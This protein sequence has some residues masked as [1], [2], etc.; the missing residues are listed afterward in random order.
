MPPDEKPISP[1]RKQTD[2]SLHAERVKAD[3]ALGEKL[4]AIDESADAVITLARARAD[5]V[6]AAARAKTDRQAIVARS[7]PRA[8]EIMVDARLA[9]DRALERERADADAALQGE[10]DQHV[11]LLSSERKDTDEHLQDE[12][13]QSDGALA[14]RDEFMGIVSHDLR[15]MLSTVVGFAA[16][17]EKG[18]GQPERADDMA[19][20]ARRIQRAAGRMNRLIGDLVDIASIEAGMLTVARE[21][22]DPTPVINEAIDSFY[23]QA[24]GSGVEL[25]AEFAVT[26]LL[27]ELDAA[28]ILQVLTNLLSNAIK[29]TPEKG[30]IVVRAERVGHDALFSIEDSGMGIATENLEAIFGRFAQVKKN[31]RRG[32]GLGL[33]I[34]KCIVQGHGGRIWAESKLGRGSTFRFTLPIQASP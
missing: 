18:V 5:A 25:V 20:N 34:S 28:R 27:V 4:A 16:L 32:L 1:E 10:R 29:F 26:P 12:R 19:V 3:L 23:A 2:E 13:A 24:V 31:D 6:L 30:R 11:A 21:L 7:G 15:N 17:I 8:N 9:A 33:F 14:T 22:A